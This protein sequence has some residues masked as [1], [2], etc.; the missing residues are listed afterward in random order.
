MKAKVIIT[1]FIVASLC[2]CARFVTT[3]TDTRNGTNTAI[4]TRVKA[5]T[6]FDSKSA[7]TAFKASQTEKSQSATVG[8]LNQETSGS[9]A[10]NMVDT[11]VRAAI[12]EAVKSTV[13]P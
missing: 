4:T 8:S 11:V 12:S 10:V 9:N 7:L 1:A 5:T 2:G 6:F 3:Q 13:K